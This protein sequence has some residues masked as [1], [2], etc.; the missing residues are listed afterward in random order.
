MPK[1]CI[2]IHIGQAGCSAGQCAWELFCTEHD[3]EKDGTRNGE[4]GDGVES[5]AFNSFF[6]ETSSGQHVPRAIFLDTDPKSKEEILCSNYRAIFHPDSLISYNEDCK[7]NFFEGW[8]KA[9][10]MKI[11]DDLMDRV[12]KAVDLC[13]NFQGF[14]VF[15]AFGGGTGAG[16]GQ[17]ALSRLKEDFSKQIIFEPVIYPS[18]HYGSCIVEPYN[19][20]F[21]THYTKEYVDLS[22]MMDNEAAYNMCMRNLGVRNP[23]FSHLNRIIAQI[24]SA[25]TTSLRFDTELNASL[26][27]IVTNIVPTKDYRYPILSIAPIRQESRGKIE[28]FNTREI[29]TE[30]FDA[31]NMLAECE[32]IERNRYLAAV[33]LLRG[34]AERDKGGFETA[35]DVGSTMSVGSDGGARLPMQVNAVKDTLQGLMN[36]RGRHRAP[37]RFLP[38]LDG[39]GF[40]VGIVGRKPRLPTDWK[41]HDGRKF[42]AETDRQGALLANTTAVR[43]LFVRQYVKFLK[44]F[45][46]KAY[47]WQFLEADGELDA[48]YEAREGVR[49]LIDSYEKLLITCRDEENVKASPQVKVF[50]ETGTHASAG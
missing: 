10:K 22:L 33:V 1:E 37:L 3:I 24:T 9:N 16:V 34:E 30:L 40:K 50:G 12:S 32:E 49:D 36:P 38:W 48:F 45:Y 8:G 5:E 39:G 18:K 20:I 47:V 21:A 29:I 14:F 35:S 44:L 25:V 41:T 6:Y 11:I 26:L 27:E 46:R 15:H 17:M 4:P 23:H 7:N 28:Q 2:T 31:K 13:S 42:M 19:C 43:Q